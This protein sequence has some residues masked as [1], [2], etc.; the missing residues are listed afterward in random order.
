MIFFLL[1]LLKL[2][3]F[4][5][6]LSPLQLYNLSC[7]VNEIIHLCSDCIHFFL[8]YLLVISGKM[9]QLGQKMSVSFVVHK[10]LSTEANSCV[11]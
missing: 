7:D 9:I 10:N 8:S 1:F 3:I 5:L 4:L 6:P 11:G 2:F